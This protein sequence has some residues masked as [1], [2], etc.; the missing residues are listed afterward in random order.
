MDY[1][2]EINRINSKLSQLEKRVIIKNIYTKYRWSIE[3][4]TNNLL[5]EQ[6]VDGVWT[7]AYSINSL[8]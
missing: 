3:D 5:I 1:R 7:E 8:I 2:K 4:G 6:L